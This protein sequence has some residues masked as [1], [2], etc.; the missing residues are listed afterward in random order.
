MQLP[1]TSFN[2]LFKASQDLLSF[3]CTTF[4]YSKDVILYS[5]RIKE[6]LVQLGDEE[7]ANAR[8]AKN[9]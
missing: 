7:L 3:Y 2:S 5:A 4:R 9:A 1:Q 8:N 6:K